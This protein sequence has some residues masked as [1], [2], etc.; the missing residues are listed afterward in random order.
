MHHLIV[1]VYSPP[2]SVQEIR[3]S[4]A[5]RTSSMHAWATCIVHCKNH[6]LI[7]S[8]V[9][10]ALNSELSEPSSCPHYCTTMDTIHPYTHIQCQSDLHYYVHSTPDERSPSEEFLRLDQKGLDIRNRM[11]KMILLIPTN[12][13][14]LHIKL[15]E[16]LTMSFFRLPELHFALTRLVTNQIYLI[17]L[18]RHPRS[19][20]RQNSIPVPT[21]AKHFDPHNSLN[22][23][24]PLPPLPIKTTSI[25]FTIP[26]RSRIDFHLRNTTS[27]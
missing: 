1:H 17:M 3:L 26:R 9:P 12:V 19:L 13:C 10:H 24:L 20:F 5:G 14:L 2:P 6:Q 4:C 18:P 15:E 21:M 23:N 8:Q 27:H 25:P 16:M 22:P 7:G 11:E